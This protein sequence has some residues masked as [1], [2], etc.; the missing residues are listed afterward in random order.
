MKSLL[1]LL[2]FCCGFIACKDDP[3]QTTTPPPTR[4]DSLEIFRKAFLSPE[5]CKGCHPRHYE[6]WSI[7]MHAY[8]VIDP[9]FHSLNKLGQEQTQGRLGEFCVAC[10][11]PFAP[12]LQETKDGL[13]NQNLS[14]VAAGAVSCDGCHKIESYVP[15]HGITKFRTDKAVAGS[16]EDPQFTA[17]HQSVFDPRFAVGEICSGCHDVVN[18]RGVRVEQTFTEWNNS[19]Y[20]RQIIECQTCHMKWEN[21]AIAVGGST[22][23]KYHSHVME[24]VD[25]PLT[26]FPGRDRMI[27]L[28]QYQLDYSLL[29][30]LNAPEVVKRGSPVAIDYNMSNNI[31]GH[32]VPS[33][34]IFERQM[35][36]EVVVTNEKGDTVLSSGLLDPNRDLRND[37]S[38]YVK[39]GLLPKDSLLVLFNGQAYRHGKEIPFFFDADA[40]VNHTIPPLESR[41]ARYKVLPQNYADAKTLTINVRLMFRAMPPY[42]L[43]MLGHENLIERLPLFTMEKASRTV[44]IQ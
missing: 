8:A 32:N 1:L 14:P 38:E 33:G 11:A 9:V 18:S 16:I 25:V 36:V 43:R 17:F 42:F 35:W 30:F 40:V 12:L 23:R 19:L 21:G 39:K 27:S 2:T 3:P 22:D 20:P 4:A 15:G 31:T 28:I 10:H 7:S 34:T 26:D 24:G 29:T 13:P 5:D 41:T 44:T 6:D 37:H